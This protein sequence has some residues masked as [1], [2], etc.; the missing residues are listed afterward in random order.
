MGLYFCS[1]DFLKSHFCLNPNGT[2]SQPSAIQAVCFGVIARTFCGSILIPVTVIKTRYESGVFSY[3]SLRQALRHTYASEGPRGLISGLI[4]TLMRDAPFSGLY[5]MFYSQMRN[6][7]L[8]SSSTSSNTKSI[9]PIVT[10]TIGL[11]A[12][13][14]ASFVTHPMDVVSSLFYLCICHQMSAHKTPISVYIQLISNSRIIPMTLNR[15]IEG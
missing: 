4:P 6:M 11:N 8:S 5:F 13:L 15:V 1:L 10:F 2:E 14:M 12:G 9:S 3:G 7:A